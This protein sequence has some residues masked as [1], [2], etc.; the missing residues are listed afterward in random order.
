[1]KDLNTLV[2]DAGV[3][4]ILFAASDDCAERVISA[5]EKT[6]IPV[7]EILQRSETALKVFKDAVKLRKNSYIGAGTV[8]TLDHCKQ[9]VDLGA[10]FIVSPGY[11]PEVVNWCVKNNVPIVPGISNTTELMMAADAGVTL[12]KFFPFYELG[13]E[14][15]LNGISGPFPNMKFIITGCI[16]DREL[17]YLTNHKIAAIGGVWPF[18]SESNHAVISEEEIIHRLNRTME[19]GRHYRSERKGWQ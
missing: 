3:L 18:Q 13:G 17:P 1:M 5:I 15:F 14:K 4:P 10:D 7:V 8:R 2:F 9:M 16:D 12:A 6:E 11:N 19:L